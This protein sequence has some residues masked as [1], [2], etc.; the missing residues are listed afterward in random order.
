M[1]TASKRFRGSQFRGDA[2]HKNA[3]GMQRQG[4]R[5]I[6]TL[7]S[8]LTR[9]EVTKIKEI[10]MLDP[11]R[12]KQFLKAYIQIWH[13]IEHLGENLSDEH[14]EDEEEEDDGH[15]QSRRMKIEPLF[16]GDRQPLDE[17]SIFPVYEVMKSN[18]KGAMYQ[19]VNRCEGGTKKWQAQ[20][21]LKGYG[22]NG[23]WNAG[24]YKSA[25]IAARAVAVA[26]AHR[27]H[28]QRV[29]ELMDRIPQDRYKEI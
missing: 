25:Q 15:Y 17:V 16:A 3:A 4:K 23:R 10:Y 29:L 24:Y 19:Y 26:T 1:D 20:P 5:D 22:T 18:R 27:C 11:V 28:Q 21:Y 6:E 9:L 8:D 2:S 14:P 13:E 12:K 7:S